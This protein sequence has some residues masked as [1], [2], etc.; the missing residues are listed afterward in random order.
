MLIQ[1]SENTDT[2]TVKVEKLYNFI[3]DA[4]SVMVAYSGGVDSSL[5][6]YIT[7]KVIGYERSLMVTAASPAVSDNEVSLAKIQARQFGWRH[8]VLLTNEM[9]NSNYVENNIQ[10]CY[11]CKHELYSKMSQLADEEKIKV[12]INGTNSDD[13]S[14]YR[15]GNTASKQLNVVSPLADFGMSKKD[16]RILAKKFSLPSWDKPAQPC[17]A[18][19]LPYGTK[20][21]LKALTMVDKA[22]TVLHKLGFLNVR[23]RHHYPV[24]RIELDTQDFSRLLNKETRLEIDKSL[25]VIG[26]RY[27]SLDLAPLRSG[28]LNYF[29]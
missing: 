15:P 11:F 23:V 26:Y 12:I 10:R 16:V 1:D 17:L 13:L 29:I 20:V 18:S 7:H 9:N 5:V 4:G 3:S 19:R 2:L 25:K 6:A 22:E 24:A 14:D 21:S 8:K 28:N 27:I